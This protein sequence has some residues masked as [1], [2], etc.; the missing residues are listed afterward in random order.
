MSGPAN[1]PLQAFGWTEERVNLLKRHFAVGLT[2][3]ES[4]ILL[5]VSKNAVISKRNRLGLT[6]FARAIGAGPAVKR[7]MRAPMLR[8]AR[9]PDFRRLP[10]PAMDAAPPPDA[11]PKPLAQHKCGE[12]VWPLGRADEAGDWRTLFCCA[13][14]RLGVRYCQTHAARSRR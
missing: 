11:N 10:L 12:C 4:A 8:I 2:A 1:L 3:T 14:V 13:P 7:R 6:G 5:C 9:E